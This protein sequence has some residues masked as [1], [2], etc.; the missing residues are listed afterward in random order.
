MHYLWHYIVIGIVGGF[1][2]I[3]KGLNLFFFI[4]SNQKG[5]FINKEMRKREL[6]HP[7]PTNDTK[8]AV[9]QVFQPS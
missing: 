8:L 6:L 9:H 1:S 7:L 4:F 2:F 5:M 3:F